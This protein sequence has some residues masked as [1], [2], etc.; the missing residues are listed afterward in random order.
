MLPSLRRYKPSRSLNLFTLPMADMSLAVPICCR[1]FHAWATLTHDA[2]WNCLG[3]SSHAPR[4]GRKAMT[5]WNGCSLITSNCMPSFSNVI[6]FNL[7]QLNKLK[8][9]IWPLHRNWACQVNFKGV[10]STKLLIHNWIQF[11]G[12]HSQRLR[13]GLNTG[14]NFEHNYHGGNVCVVVMTSCCLTGHK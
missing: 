10:W 13:C 12:C 2:A 7:W 11:P 4:R 14:L 6:H 9:G 5:T 8:G 3:S 1:S